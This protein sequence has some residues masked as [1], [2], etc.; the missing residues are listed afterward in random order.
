MRVP[1]YLNPFPF[2]N[3]GETKEPKKLVEK[4][5]K[6]REEM[7]WE[8]LQIREGKRATNP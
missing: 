3:R 5:K 4:R 6:M 7:R 8:L 2:P 1:R